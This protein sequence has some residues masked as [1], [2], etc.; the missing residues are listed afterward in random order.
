VPL[1]RNLNMPTTNLSP[2]LIQKENILPR[3]L[4]PPLPVLPQSLFNR[5]SEG[6]RTLLIPFTLDKTAARRPIDLIPAKPENL[7]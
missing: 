4:P 7:A 3:N 5:R 2:E 6:N 1:Q